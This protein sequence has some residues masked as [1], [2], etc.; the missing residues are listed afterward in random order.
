MTTNQ[1][2]YW[3]LQNEKSKAEETKRSNLENERIKRDTLSETS[4]HNRA[5][6]NVDM[7]KLAESIRHNQATEGLT[8]QQLLELVRSNKV[9]EALKQGTLAET[10][11][12][13]QAQEALKAS[14]NAI[15]D[16]TSLRNFQA[17]L[18]Q[19]SASLE[20]TRVIESGNNLRAIADSL[21]N[22][23]RDKGLDIEAEKVAN[24]GR[25]ID[26]SIRHNKVSE[27]IDSLQAVNGILSGLSN[28]IGSGVKAAA[29]IGG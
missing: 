20:N 5:T 29:V 22:Q 1:I 23:L 4:T 14:A 28:V 10:I 2:N 8:M 24:E 6:E 9:N 25:K 7:S 13:N 18:Q 12:S 21:E 27:L 15:A 3:N 17:K 11:R 26:E 16:I 19:V